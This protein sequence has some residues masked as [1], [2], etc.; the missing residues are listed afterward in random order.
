MQSQLFMI[1]LSQEG[2]EKRDMI[3]DLWER[4]KEISELLQDS[5]NNN[6]LNL[7]CINQGS[8]L[9]RYIIS[10]DLFTGTLQGGINISIL[11]IN[12]AAAAAAAAV[13]L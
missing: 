1:K 7:F 12:I 10:L 2:M 8:I 5:H 3:F 13:S 11:Q 9:I 4:L 6:L